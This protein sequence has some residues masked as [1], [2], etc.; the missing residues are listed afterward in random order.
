MRDFNDAAREK[1]STR[2]K[3]PGNSG[4]LS[5]QKHARLEADIKA[6][7]RDGYLPC[8]AAWKI[9]REA[10]VTKIAVGEACDRMGIRVTDCQIGFFKKSKTPYENDGRENID[11][12][13]VSELR[14][15]G[16]RLTCAG[17]FELAKKHKIKPLTLSHEAGA[18]GVKIGECQLGCF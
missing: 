4:N 12:G 2:I 8:P 13:A 17:V 10:G 9:A 3:L 1:K 11:E 16:G 15:L 5:E 18:L 6:S 14:Q 7:L